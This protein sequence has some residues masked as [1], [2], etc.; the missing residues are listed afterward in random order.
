MC[1]WLAYSGSP[2]VLEQLLYEPEHSLI[3]QSLH[4]QL[5]AEETNGDGFGVGWYGEQA[6]PAVFRSIEPAWNDRNLRELV[7]PRHVGARVRAH[8]CVDRLTGAADQLPSVP[9]RTLAVDAQ[10]LHRRVRPGEARPGARSRSVALLRDRGNDRHGGVLQPRA[11]VRAGRR[12]ARCSRARGRLHRGDRPPARRREPDP[13][14][15]RDDGRRE[16]LGVSLRERRASRGRS[17]TAP[18][19]GHCVLSTRRWRCSARSPTSRGSSSR[20]RWDARRRVERGAAVELRRHPGRG[21]PPASPS[22]LPSEDRCPTPQA[23]D[24][25]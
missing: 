22:R 13:D 1:R 3:V 21:R 7:R 25:G 16:R 18:T 4:S 8:P 17:S 19:S 6:T 20:S 14:D 5:G 24:T 12:S 23:S 10:R 2:L 9:P 11:H 15:G